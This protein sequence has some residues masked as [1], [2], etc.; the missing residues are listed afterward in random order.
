MKSD[1][2]WFVTLNV[3]VK[4]KVKQWTTL[5]V[6]KAGGLAGLLIV[7]LF[8]CWFLPDTSCLEKEKYNSRE[9]GQERR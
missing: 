2:N 9:E 3:W 8:V 5:F 7:L 6:C 4:S 1:L